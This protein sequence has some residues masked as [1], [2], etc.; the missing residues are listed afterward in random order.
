MTAFTQE[1]IDYLANLWGD[2]D[3]EKLT[4]AQAFGLVV[5]TSFEEGQTLKDVVGEENAKTLTGRV[6]DQLGFESPRPV[7]SL[8]SFLG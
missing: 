2:L 3:P 4:R 6:L 8:E 7:A 1:Q 5:N